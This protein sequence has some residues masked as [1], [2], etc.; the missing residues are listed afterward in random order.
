MAMAV[1]P[2]NVN[3]F[4]PEVSR[5][6]P[7]EQRGGGVSRQSFTPV[8]GTSQYRQDFEEISRLGKGAFGEVWMCRRRL[9]GWRYAVKKLGAEAR[10]IRGPVTTPAMLQEVG[11]MIL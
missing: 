10:R 8:S 11:S 2:C 4:S 3:P 6:S 9:D 7:G 1:P 5:P